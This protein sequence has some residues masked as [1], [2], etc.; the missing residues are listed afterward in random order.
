MEPKTILPDGSVEVRFRA[1]GQTKMLHHL[2]TWED[3]IV[4]IEP[5][6]LR[7]AYLALHDRIRGQLAT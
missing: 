7:T 1:T 5:P 4:D 2:V 6:E 3:G